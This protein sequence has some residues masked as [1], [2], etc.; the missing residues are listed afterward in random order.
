MRPKFDQIVQ[1]IFTLQRDHAPST[2][3]DSISFEP[4]SSSSL[5]SSSE[6]NMSSSGTKKRI[7]RKK[8][9]RKDKGSHSA[10]SKEDHSSEGEGKI[11][12]K[13]T[14]KVKKGQGH[15][16]AGAKRQKVVMSEEEVGMGLTLPL[17]GINCVLLDTKETTTDYESDTLLWAGSDNGNIYV[18]NTRV[19]PP[20][21]THH[22][23]YIALIIFFQ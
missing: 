23:P 5:S 7:K 10:S 13:K 9:S 15:K 16:T 21:P 11:R 6:G 12:K 14:K 8:K 19:F 20:P 4:S 18:W 3:K 17:V 1:Q 2:L 22:L